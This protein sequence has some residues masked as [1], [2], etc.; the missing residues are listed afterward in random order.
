MLDSLQQGPT[1]C[2]PQFELNSFF[3]HG[4][5]LGSRP[6]QYQR[7]FPLASHFRICNWCLVYMIQQAY[8]YVSLGLWPCL[9]FFR[10]KITY[11]LKSSGW[12]WKRV[13]CHGNK[14]FYSHSC[15]FCRTISL[16]SFNVMCCKLTKIA[17]FIYMM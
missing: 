10:L 4:N 11:I 17:L 1:K 5:I 12:D 9:M 14:M 8:K 16:P 2:A 6:L 7:H 3:Y 13:S 15:V